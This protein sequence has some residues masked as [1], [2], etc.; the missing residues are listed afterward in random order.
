MKALSPRLVLVAALFACA[1]SPAL[2]QIR[3]GKGRRSEP[4]DNSRPAQATP[5]D[6]IKVHKDFRVELLY[7]VPRA[8]QGSWV[9]MCVDSQGR[10]IVSDQGNAG[11]F[12]VT[13][14]PVGQ[15]ASADSVKIEPIKLDYTWPDGTTTAFSGAQ[16]LLWAF[17]SL[18]VVI[19]SRGGSGLYRCTDTNGDGEL[20]KVTLLRA[21]QGGGGEHG[22][23]AVLLAPDGKSLFVVCGNQTRITDYVASRV[24]PVWG[25]D[26]LLPRMSDGN[27]FMRGVLGPGGTIYQLDPDGKE[28]TVNTV[29]FRN[30]YDAAF[31][32][33]GDLFTYDADMEW[34]FNTPWYRPTRV[35]LAASGVDYGWRNGAGKWLTYFPDTLPPTVDIGPGSPTGVT[36]GYGARF[37]AKYQDALFINDWSYGK[38]YAVHIEPDGA[39]YKGTYEEFVTGTPLPLTDIVVRP[40]DGAMYF[41][42]GG[43]NTQS[44]L[45]RVTYVGGESTAP[46]T[47]ADPAAE[48]HATRRKLEAFHTKQ[49]P[50]AV[51]TAW[52]YLGNTDRY[53]RYAARVAIEHQDPASWR[54]KALAEKEPRAALSALLALVR[55][56]CSDPYHRQSGAL[57]PLEKQNDAIADPSDKDSYPPGD[58]KLKA[59]I[60]AALGRLDFNK[61]TASQRLDLLRIY[62]VLFNRLGRPSAEQREETIARFNPLYPANLRELNGELCQ[63]LVYLRAPGVVETTLKLLAAAP[64]QEEQIAYVRDL[65]NLKTGWTLGQRKEY[66]TWFVK[67]ANYKGGNSLAGSFKIMKDDAIA[68]LTPEEKETLK[69]ILEAQ[70]ESQAVTVSPPRPFVKK[71]TLDELLGKVEAGL[72]NRDF[73]HG[74]AMFAAANCFACHRFASEGGS[75][76]PDL[77][78][79][80]GRFSMKDLL[81]SVVEPSKVISDQYQAVMIRKTDGTIVTGRII[82]LSGDGMTVNTDMLNPGRGGSVGV[83]RSEIDEMQPSP[84][85][86]MP[87][88]LLDTMNEDEVLDLLAFLLSRGERENAMFQAGQ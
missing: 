47:S 33:F 13:P 7:S 55:V 32:R 80:A 29:G 44:G 19:N 30:E 39:G 61:L 75:F 45:Y 40:Q 51:D 42:I 82:N 16:G 25:E 15:A 77:S 43:R 85:S 9:A 38:L 3:K 34:D 68:T 66:F 41:A 28:W 71:W 76:G 62:A 64:T 60:L 87:T 4:L 81:E 18:Y 84:I 27:G 73:D 83:R 17:D 46:A 10:L 22:P 31:N 6:Q 53:L 72:E 70:P 2:G 49:D 74:R 11:L 14:P 79:L 54:T 56:S 78:G 8:T 65:R 86:M 5:V 48:A 20:D 35:C 63:L 59:D 23:H 1:V 21:M 36:F 24:T 67:A 52:P 37:P 57:G 58:D 12:R 26:H 50:A 69:A 88:G